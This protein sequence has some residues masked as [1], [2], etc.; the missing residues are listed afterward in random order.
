MLNN[1]ANQF[2]VMDQ[3][4][5][6]GLITSLS[7][8]E[9]GGVNIFDQ[10]GKIDVEGK[11]R[12]IQSSLAY[13]AVTDSYTSK[14]YQVIDGIAIIPVSGTLIHGLNYISSYY[15]GYNAIVSLFD[16]ANAD[17]DV[18][19]ILKV[20]N[21]PG[22]TVAG[23]FDASD[24]IYENKGDKPVW[25]IYDDMACSG[26]M[27][28]ASAADRRFTTQTAISGSIGVVQVHVSYENMMKE[29]GMEVTLIS[30]G[31]HKLDGNPYKNLPEEVYNDFKTQSDVLKM[32]FASKVSRNIGISMDQVVET[33]AACYVGQAAINAGLADELI[34]PHNIISHFKQ[35]LSDSGRTTARSVTMTK[36]VTKN[37]ETESVNTEAVTT[38]PVISASTEA[39]PAEAVDQRARCS[40]IISSASATGR[41]DLANHLAFKTDLSADDAIKVLD[42]SPEKSVEATTTGNSLDAAMASTEQPNITSMSQDSEQSESSQYVASY[43]QVTG[44]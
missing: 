3:K 8:S 7:R 14:P 5:A 24:H 29:Y 12:I 37:I 34:N 31:T 11:P 38:K 28:M 9:K 22:G 4:A 44:E 18:K 32:Q 10:N 25:A 26:A 41:T 35:H 19:G 39:N 30:S 17:P 2:L 13:G 6:R 23:C 42:A 33:E 27:C 16:T 20:I 15:S 40:A 36:V 1:F 21:S 43:K